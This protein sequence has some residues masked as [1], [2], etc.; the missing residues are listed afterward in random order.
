M[1]GGILAAWLAG[2]GIV[3]WRDVHANHRIPAPGQLL[4]VTALFV[5]PDG[6]VEEATG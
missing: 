1:K 3:W 2:M 6:T 5:S 4:G